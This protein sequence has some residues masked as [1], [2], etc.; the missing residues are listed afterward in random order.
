MHDL[1][2]TKGAAF[3]DVLI[4]NLTDFVE[5]DNFPDYVS[6]IC[7]NL[8]INVKAQKISRQT[9]DPHHYPMQLRPQSDPLQW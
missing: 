1:R 5:S 4:R 6:G 3:F 8:V 9:C 7:L 2:N